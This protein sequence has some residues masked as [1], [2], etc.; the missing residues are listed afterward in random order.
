MYK[1][2]EL[3]D[4]MKDQLYMLEGSVTGKEL[5]FKDFDDARDVIRQHSELLSEL[6]S[7]LALA[8]DQWRLEAP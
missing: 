4:R 5:S 1:V 8:E 7:Q 2:I 3:I 6:S